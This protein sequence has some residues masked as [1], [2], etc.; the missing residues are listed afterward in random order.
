[1]RRI[2][3]ISANSYKIC[4][5][6]FFPCFGDWCRYNTIQS[7]TSRYCSSSIFFLLL[8]VHVFWELKIGKG[9]Y[10]LRMDSTEYESNKK[11]HLLCS[12]IEYFVWLP[13]F[14]EQFNELCST[15]A[16][17][18]AL[19]FDRSPNSGWKQKWVTFESPRIGESN[20]KRIESSQHLC[21]LTL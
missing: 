10:L 16:Y 6:G 12:E 17:C 9:V 5:D 14:H 20:V 1:M 7:M 21:G 19:L 8:L 15:D 2:Y 11:S 4:T 13:V 3:S 18:L